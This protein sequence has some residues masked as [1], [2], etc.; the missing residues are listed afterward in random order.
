[1]PELPEVECVRRGLTRARLQAPIRSVWRSDLALRIGT[2]WRRENLQTLDAGTGTQWIRRGKFL[3][4]RLQ[5]PRADAGLLVHL[6]MTGRLL[7]TTPD[8]PAPAHTHL[9]IAFA[10]GRELRFVDARRFGGLRAGAWETLLAE[11]P[12]VELGPEPLSRGFDAATLAGRG[13]RSRRT[14]YAVLLDQRVV[15]GLGNIYVQEALYRA[16]IRPQR[17]AT[18]VTAPQWE[19]LAEAIVEVLQQGIRNGG[20]SFRDYR[21]AA[22]ERGR[23]QDRLWVYG[24]AGQVCRGCGSVLRAFEEAGRRAVFCPSEQR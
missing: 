5:T 23:N 2:T 8:E 24:R 10:D 22:G 18:R 7:V 16:G 15:A 20:T 11:P 4:W 9:R 21:N 19:R 6:G 13:G 14:I 3:L 12:L 17:R 1:M